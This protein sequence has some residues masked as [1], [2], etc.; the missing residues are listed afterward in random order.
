[1]PIKKKTAED[2]SA[3]VEVKEKVDAVVTA[4]APVSVDGLGA[5]SAE[6]AFVACLGDP[7]RDDVTTIE[8]PDGSKT[9]RVDP[10]IV[11]Y[12]LKAL[13]DVEVP[14]C[15]PGDDF[16]N[17]FMS[18]TG[19]P[20]A[21]RTVK[22]GEEFDVTKFELGMLVSRPEY[23]GSFTGG[24]TPVSAAYSLRGA[25]GSDGKA[26]ISASTQ[27][28]TVTLKALKGSVKDTMMVNVLEFTKEKDATT[29]AIRKNRTI[30]P[31]FE[32]FEPL[33]KVTARATGSGV[34]KTAANTRSKG[35]E[36]FLRIVQAK[37]G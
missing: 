16:K 28:P 33:C 25:K 12:R 2:V 24:N 19:D 7:S 9:K 26:L 22:A 18:Y 8:N 17:N 32:K 4:E 35:A 29:G 13:A 34:A 3:Q 21:T 11:G 1:M 14:N 31:G 27:I 30:L 15:P 37:K 23:N 20:T 6:I 36:T 10:T 5:K